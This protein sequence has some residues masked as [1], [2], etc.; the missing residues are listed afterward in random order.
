MRR[1]AGRDGYPDA[2]D[3]RFGDAGGRREPGRDR[4]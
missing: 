1:A 2:R 3:G 4:R